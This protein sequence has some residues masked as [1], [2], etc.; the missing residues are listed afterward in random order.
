MSLH[1]FEIQYKPLYYIEMIEGLSRKL[2]YVY[3][4][5]Q[6]I[7]SS[8]NLTT[9][10]RYWFRDFGIFSYSNL[11]NSL[12]RIIYVAYRY[13]HLSFPP[14]PIHISSIIYSIHP[15]VLYSFLILPP[16]NPPF[17]YIPSFLCVIPF[18]VSF[19]SHTS[20]LPFLCQLELE[21]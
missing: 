6:H 18:L 9:I 15:S 7:Y 20:F 1:I 21:I 10:L 11:S 4:R 14:S 12:D 16:T 3:L 19:S 17:S 8:A 2:S 13:Y 5:L